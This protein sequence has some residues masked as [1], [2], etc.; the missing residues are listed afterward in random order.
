MSRIVTF[1]DGF[2]SATAPVVSGSNLESYAL[3]NNQALTN[4]TGLV[5]DGSE[6]KAVFFEYELERIGSSN[7]RQVGSFI[8]VYKDSW[9]ISFGNYQGDTI[10]EDTLVNPESITLSIIGAS[11]QFQYSSGNQSGH[12]SS[13]LKL[14]VLKVIA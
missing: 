3:S 14:N 10:I 4:I 8:A 1:A 13:K 6:V 5:F 11:G 2:S 7:Y 9:S 12:T